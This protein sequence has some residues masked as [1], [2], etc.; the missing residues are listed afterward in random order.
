M[1][2]PASGHSK[3]MRRK[4]RKNAGILISISLLAGGWLGYPFLF[5]PKEVIALNRT[6][7]PDFSASADNWTAGN[8][9]G[10]D[11]CSTTTATGETAMAAFAYDGADGNPSGSFQAITGTTASENYKGKIVQSFTAP[12]TGS[13]KAKGKFDYKAGG[14]NWSS[15]DTSWVRLDIYDSSDTDHVASLGC[16]S[17]NS[18]QAWTSAA[19]SNEI[20][21]SGGTTYSLR[22]TLRSQNGASAATNTLAIDNII[23]NFAPT[24]L[25][26]SAPADSIDASLSWTASTGTPPLHATAPYKIY[27]GTVSADAFLADSASASYLDESTAGNTLYYY[28]IVD[29]DENGVFSPTSSEASILTR[30]ADPGDPS[31]SNIGQTGLDV[32]WN[33]PSGGAASYKVERAPDS[34]GS[35]GSWTEVA[36]GTSSPWTDGGLACATGYWYRVRGTNATGDGLYS[37]NASTTTAACSPVVSIT[38]DDGAVSFGTLALGATS[39]NAGDVQVISVDSGPADLDIRSTAWSDGSVAWSLGS[40]SSTNQVVWEFSKDNSSWTTF[41]IPDNLY[42]FDTNVASSATR[43][44]YLRLTMPSGTDGYGLSSSTVTIVASAP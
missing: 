9:S 25:A 13:V 8:G 4:G 28:A 12:G 32:S 2:I 6:A 36:A 38:V 35:P 16:V 24:G 26:A 44:L 41:L 1:P 31:F 40:S 15:A 14:S 17:L 27:R 19:F 5:S 7:N 11:G 3:P 39:S 20:E 29:V 21:L 42:A 23:L 30:P 33:A 43:D 37:N 10:T 34:G 18:D 22:A